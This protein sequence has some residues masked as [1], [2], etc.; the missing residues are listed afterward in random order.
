MHV[1]LNRSHVGSSAHPILSCPPTFPYARMTQSH[2]QMM[3]FNGKSV[4]TVDISFNASG[5]VLVETIVKELGC[6]SA[7]FSISMKENCVDPVTALGDASVITGDI[8][9][10]TN[11]TEPPVHNCI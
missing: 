11:L 8:V 4:G 10:I 3:K 5:I 6:A 9:T 2:L 1:E 7:T